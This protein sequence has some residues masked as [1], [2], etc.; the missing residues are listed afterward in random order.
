MNRSFRSQASGTTRNTSVLLMRHRGTPIDD[1]IVYADSMSV[2][3]DMY[4]S[5]LMDQTLQ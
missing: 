1:T 4:S 3:R 2:G 5:D